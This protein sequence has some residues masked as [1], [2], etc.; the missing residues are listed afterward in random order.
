MLQEI[1]HATRH[2]GPQVERYDDG[3]VLVTWMKP[4]RLT[5]LARATGICRELFCVDPRTHRACIHI[6][7]EIAE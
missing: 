5:Q 6:P 1:L 2:W 7:R 3:D 4:V